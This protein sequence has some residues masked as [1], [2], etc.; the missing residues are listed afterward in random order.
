MGVGSTLREMAGFL[1]E[2]ESENHTVRSVTLAEGDEGGE[3]GA[4]TADVEL[5][6]SA[7]PADGRPQ[8]FS[9]SGAG[10]D[11]DGRVALELES[12]ASIVPPTDNDVE[13]RLEDATIDAEGTLVLSIAATVATVDRTDGTNQ[14]AADERLDSITTLT[15][16]VETNDDAGTSSD[17]PDEGAVDDTH[18]D[19][20]PF[21]DPDLLQTVYESCDTFAEMRA[22]LGMDVTPETVRRYMID[23][24]IH[25]P[26]SYKTNPDRV[27]ARSQVVLTDGIGLP[28][29][30]TVERLI[31]TVKRSRTIYEVK[32]ELNMEQAAARELL[33]ELNLLDLVVG[34]LTRENEREIRREDVIER[35]REVSR[36]RS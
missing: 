22:E 36:S 9:V 11:E 27:D 25:E 21:R 7:C 13:I 31:E 20:P 23:H 34:R 16:S 3:D 8:P 14:T 4:V 12:V 6:V 24:G 32:Q 18:R 5:A 10:V 1:D 17:P 15:K 35:L 19:V 33:R 30:V 29:N 26:N 2:C 28:E